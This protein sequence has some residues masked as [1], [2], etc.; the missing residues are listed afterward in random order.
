MLSAEVAAF[1]RTILAPKAFSAV[2]DIIPASSNE[3]IFSDLPGNE[4]KRPLA[5][6]PTG[7]PLPEEAWAP[8][9]KG[10]YKAQASAVGVT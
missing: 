3:C 1:Q 10:G 2:H 6:E 7:A 9:A 5:F 4:G 8:A